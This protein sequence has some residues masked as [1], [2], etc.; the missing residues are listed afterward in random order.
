MFFTS[1]IS[2][3][4]DNSND[5][6]TDRSLDRGTDSGFLTRGKTGRAIAAGIDIAIDFATLG[7]Y[8]VVLDAPVTRFAEDAGTESLWATG[9]EWTTPDRSR[10]TCSL[11]RAR[12][13][14]WAKTR[15]RG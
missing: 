8:R 7:E 15:I 9:I 13:R 6:S 12:N 10:A 3:T 14:D 11:P 4:A 2:I 1:D 5:N